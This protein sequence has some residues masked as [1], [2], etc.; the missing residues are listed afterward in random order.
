MNELAKSCDF[1]GTRLMDGKVIAVIYG[2]KIT[3]EQ[4]SGLLND[5]QK[6]A[7]TFS[8]IL[9]SSVACWMTPVI[10]FFN[11]GKHDLVLAELF[12][13]GWH[14]SFWEKTYVQLG[15]VDCERKDVRYCKSRGI[16]GFGQ[17]IVLKIVQF[18]K[19]K[20]IYVLM[21]DALRKLYNSEMRSILTRE[22]IERFTR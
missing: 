3:I 8:N 16:V 13:A 10:V 18:F 15:I 22:D 19:N 5:L 11:S 1:F 14:S 20:R 4:L 17:G 21:R 7:K 2:D 12:P 9:P 6:T